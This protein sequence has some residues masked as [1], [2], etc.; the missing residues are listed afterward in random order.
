MAAI[1][2]VNAC[3]TKIKDAKFKI[4]SNEISLWILNKD[5]NE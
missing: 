1:H 3:L 2:Q 4:H 5:K